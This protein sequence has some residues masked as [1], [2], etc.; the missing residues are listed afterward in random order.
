VTADRP[1]EGVGIVLTRARAQ[2]EP[3]RQALGARGAR[4]IV[5][6]C[7]EIVRKEP[8][9]AGQRALASL[10][11]ARLA[12]FVSA[13]AVE[14]GLAAARTAAPWPQEVAVAAI[15]EATAAALLNSGFTRVISP[16]SRFDSES[17]LA[18]P[19]LQAVKAGLVV[20]FRGEGGRDELRRA[21]E[22]R[23]A[24]VSCVECYRRVRPA[25]DAT[26]VLAAFSRGEIQAV[27]AMSA[28]TVD[29]FMALAGGRAAEYLQATALIVPHEAVA[30]NAATRFA[31]VLVAAPDADAMQ[32]ALLNLPMNR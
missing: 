27:H 3:L 7:L 24:A 29:N 28:E 20:I 2:S 19:E 25:T 16:A 5:F 8:G 13:N 21:L 30:R 4:V 31:R 15:G 12:I 1:L 32:H 11:S 10:A 6:P 17:L 22:A 26:Q 14:H 23:G 18:L 9:P